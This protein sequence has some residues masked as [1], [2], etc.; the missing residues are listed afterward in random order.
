MYEK[1]G[2][3]YILT[4]VYNKVLYTGVTSDL[5]K[6]VYQ[7]KNKLAEGFTKKYNVSKLVHYDVF[8]DIM[9]AIER[10]KQIKGWVRR[11]KIALIETNNPAW[12]DLWE[13]ITG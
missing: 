1:K 3:T 11:K 4:N 9:S 10:E 8:E 12:K 13:E 2:Y 5:I 7:H 6:R